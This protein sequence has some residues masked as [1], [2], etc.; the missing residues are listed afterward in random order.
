MKKTIIFGFFI[1]FFLLGCTSTKVQVI[2]GSVVAGD[3]VPVVDADSDNVSVVDEGVDSD[4]VNSDVDNTVDNESEGSDADG[5]DQGTDD[6]VVDNTPASACSDLSCEANKICDE[7]DDCVCA[8]GKE[9][10]EH[11][12]LC[13]N[14]DV[15]C[16]NFDCSSDE[17]CI[18]TINV[19]QICVD[20]GNK[21]CKYVQEGR[22]SVLNPS[23]N[24][25]EILIKSVMPESVEFFV[26]DS[27][28][29]TLTLGD[30]YDLDGIDVSVRKINLVESQCTET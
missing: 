15:C 28:L 21:S 20:D 17:K 3:S 10:C 18:F 13:I 12:N 11:Q 1:L 24:L 16:S 27:E 7:D 8:E 19:A 14:E 29:I 4:D 9:W 2:S 23:G 6:A 25:Y 22:E 30:S 5:S 26:G